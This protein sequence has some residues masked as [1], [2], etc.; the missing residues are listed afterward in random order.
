MELSPLPPSAGGQGRTPQIS[1]GTLFGL[2]R[3]AP[4]PGSEQVR[5]LRGVV[6]SGVEHHSRVLVGPQGQVLA[7]LM[8]GP[9][10]VL[11]DGQQVLVTGVFV[12][13]LLTTAQQGVPFRVQTA[14]ADDQ[15][16]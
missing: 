7:Q 2:G 9:P 16:G 8:G 1:R 6:R 11:T 14:E 15:P 12:P 4:A 5:Q 3:Q 13:D 10:T